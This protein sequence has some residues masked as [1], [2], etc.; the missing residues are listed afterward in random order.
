MLR[1]V[2]K[3]G[4]LTVLPAA[5]AAVML[6]AASC[7]PGGLSVGPSAETS[8]Y[9]CHI[10]FKEEALAAVHERHRVT[11]VR[12]HGRSLAH[13]EDEVRKTPADVTFKGKAMEVF[14]LT[15]HGRK[16]HY[17]VVA[18][19][20]EAKKDKRRTCTQCHGSHRLVRVPIEGVKAN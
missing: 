13:M 9:E 5:V 14:C 20:A 19:E 15:C 7:Q 12:C 8:C 1:Y 17:R 18:H 6:V 2:W 10:D 4:L 3:L 16:R 11:C